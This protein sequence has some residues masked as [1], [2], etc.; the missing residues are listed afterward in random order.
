MKVGGYADLTT[1]FASHVERGRPEL[2]VNSCQT[3][4]I[5]CRISEQVVEPL[6]TIDTVEARG[7]RF[8]VDEYQPVLC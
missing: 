3:F 6:R 1:V 4:A 2:L 8:Q 7:R 5:S